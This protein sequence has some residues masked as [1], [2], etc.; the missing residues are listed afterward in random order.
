MNT[1]L[2]HKTVEVS[3]K[4]VKFSHK[5]VEALPK[6]VEVS[7]K[8]VEVSHKNVEVSHKIVEVLYKVEVELSLQGVQ[9]FSMLD[10]VAT[11]IFLNG[12]GS[13][14]TNLIPRKIV[15]EVYM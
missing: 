5:T 8:N 1:Q 10:Y 9:K 6:N 14:L 2:P 15:C 7:H 4:N 13:A 11:L 12:G 3:H